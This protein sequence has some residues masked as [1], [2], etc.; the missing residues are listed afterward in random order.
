MLS[1]EY[2]CA[3]FQSSLVFLHHFVLA[4]LANSSIRVS[5]QSKARSLEL[6]LFKQIVIYNDLLN[7]YHHMIINE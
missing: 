4:K 5:A 3:M 7:L 2:P 1:D 6:L